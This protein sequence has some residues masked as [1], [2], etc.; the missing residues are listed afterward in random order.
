MDNLSPLNHPE[1]PRGRKRRHG[2]LTVD[3]WLKEVEFEAEKGYWREDVGTPSSTSASFSQRSGTPTTHRRNFKRQK[4]GRRIRDDEEAG[5]L[6]KLPGLEY[7][8]RSV[9]IRALDKEIQRAPIDPLLQEFFSE[10]P[11]YSEGIKP[12]EWVFVEANSVVEINHLSRFDREYAPVKEKF[13]TA[14]EAATDYVAHLLA[15]PQKLPFPEKEALAEVRYTGSKYAGVE[16]ALMGAKTRSDADSLAQIDAEKA[17][18]DLMDGIRVEPHKNRMGGRGKLVKL[19][20]LEAQGDQP[21]A[22]RFILMTSHRD[23]K[24]N[25]ATQQPLT[26]AYKH[27]SFP[28]SVGKAWWH[29]GVHEFLERFADKVLFSCLDAKKF[30]SSLPGWLLRLGINVLREQFI[31]GN[32]PKYDAYWDFVYEGLAEAVVY[33][34]NGMMFKRRGGSTSGHS[35]NTLVQSVCTLIIMYTCYFTLLP[36]EEWDN[37]GDY[38]WVESLGDDQHTGAKGPCEKFTIE[39]IAPIALECFGVDWFGDKSFNTTRLYDEKEGDFQGTQYLGKYFRLLDEEVGGV[40]VKGMVPYRP[41]EE[42]VLRLLYPERGKMGAEESWARAIGHYADA[43]GLKKTRDFLDA[44]MDWLEP[45][46]ETDDFTWGEKWSR[47]FAGGDPHDEH[48]VPAE[49]IDYPTWLGLVLLDE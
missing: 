38:V 6:A 43:A 15:L 18:D 10:N 34:D 49:R 30:D 28:I 25:G 32:N 42:T 29:N 40:R 24:V 47:K 14:I 11:Q 26:D 37:I 3:G 46:V 12:E 16:Y 33:M 20:K 7:I 13:E 36:R 35:H 8:G 23:L 9:P 2:E 21:E 39:E 4:A 22:G 19:A 48:P 17:W 45:K 5:I 41:Y 27:P 44:Y 31:D 1:T